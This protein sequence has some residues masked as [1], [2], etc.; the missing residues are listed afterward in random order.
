MT[1]EIEA[2]GP[3]PQLAFSQAVRAGDTL[4]VSGQIAIGADGSL[5]G[6]GDARRQ[7]EQC[8]DNLEAVLRAAGMRLDD[9][10]KFTCFMVDVADYPAYRD[11]K[12]ARLPRTTPASTGVIVTALLVE[13]ARFELEAIAVRPSG[14]EA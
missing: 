14:D 3:S 10:V 8:F 9:V 1:T 12:V 6:A 7:A 2:I 5:V 4:Y 11:V 13:G